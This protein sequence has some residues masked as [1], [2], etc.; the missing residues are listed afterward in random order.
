MLIEP[1]G[2]AVSNQHASLLD[3]AKHGIRLRV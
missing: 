2:L 3:E 1:S